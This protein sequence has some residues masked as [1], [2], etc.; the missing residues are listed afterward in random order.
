[1]DQVITK[2][3]DSEIQ[4]TNSS[5]VIVSISDLK[6]KKQQLLDQIELLPMVRSIRA[7]IAQ[8]DSQINQANQLGVN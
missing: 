7:Q 2:A 6:T 8:I 3:S 4:I 1:M 5:T